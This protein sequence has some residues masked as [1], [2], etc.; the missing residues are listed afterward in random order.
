VTEG[1]HDRLSARRPTSRALHIEPRHGY[2]VTMIL[3]LVAALALAGAQAQPPVATADD[4]AEIAVA[5]V[6][7]DLRKAELVLDA[8]EIGD[9][10]AYSFTLVDRD[11]RLTGSFAYLEPLRRIRERGGTVKELRY[12]SLM[13]RVFG[14]SA[15]AS[16]ELHMTW[17][18]GGV[19]HRV[20]G[21]A[22]D[23]FEKRDDGAWILVHRHR[24]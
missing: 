8:D 2:N 14:A 7:E 12:D 11:G 5:A 17:T 24:P 16:Y 23:V 21:W 6:V 15:V 9:R 3:T 22:S 4:G 20:D 13:I 18:D 1:R 10:L 19:R